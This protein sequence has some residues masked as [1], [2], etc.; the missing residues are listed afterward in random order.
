MQQDHQQAALL[1][2][3]YD[4][5]V[6]TL[7]RE[8]FK[9]AG[10][11][12]W[13]KKPPEV[14]QG[15]WQKTGVRWPPKGYAIEEPVTGYF[16][17]AQPLGTEKWLV[18]KTPAGDR[19]F[20]WQ[21]EVP[22]SQLQG[23]FRKWAE[24]LKSELDAFGRVEGWS[25]P[26]AS[27][28]TLVQLVE[29]QE[30]AASHGLSARDVLEVTHSGLEHTSIR[31]KFKQ[32][33]YA[34]SFHKRWEGT[35]SPG[36]IGTSDPFKAQ[37]WAQVLTHIDTWLGYVKREMGVKFPSPPLVVKPSPPRLTLCS[38]TLRRIRKFDDVIINFHPHVNLFCGRNGTG[39]S[40]LLRC[41][42]L[43]LC[44]RAETS[45]IL[46]SVPGGLIRV[47]AREAVI[48]LTAID[49]QDEMKTFKVEL[50]RVQ[51]REVVKAE[52]KPD[53]EMEPFL[54][55]YGSTFT[56]R[57]EHTPQEYSV[58]EASESLFEDAAGLFSLEVVLRRMKEQFGSGYEQQLEAVSRAVGFH[59]VP[60]VIPGKGVRFQDNGHTLPFDGLADGF[61]VSLSWMVDLFGW[62]MLGESLV[63]NQP[64]GKLLC[65]EVDKHMHPELQAGLVQNLQNLL[66][67]MQLFL[68]THNP[69]TVLGCAPE[70]LH[71][72]REREHRVV[73][74][75]AP[76]YHG[77]SVEDVYTDP[78]LFSV[79]PF[80]PDVQKL[81]AEY[82]DIL[83]IPPSERSSQQEQ[84]L[85][86][87]AKKMMALQLDTDL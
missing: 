48:E 47:D 24:L 41:L 63:K 22:D 1:G 51:D 57:S 56:M 10:N 59:G 28:L 86:Q 67:R 16:F 65:D 38:L 53:L 8:D 84:C 80:A 42:V 68:T 77:Y 29:V 21:A 61:R 69:L 23:L 7:G 64:E 87:V 85:R 83:Q 19:C 49:D 30:V 17:A 37:N 45:A 73:C 12:R 40:T 74:E 79:N 76:D 4:V 44:H 78:R 31:F 2:I 62:A 81:I 35:H 43:A 5:G 55:G 14:L 26:G 82:H 70:S 18:H 15:N 71:I 66:P 3:L 46:T 13:V 75:S 34:F 20:P 11:L 9:P 60:V 25:G 33:I 50:E 6:H 72:L 32:K 36:R 27:M 52:E 39:K 54:C 58:R